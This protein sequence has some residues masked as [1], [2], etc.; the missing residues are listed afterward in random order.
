MGETLVDGF[1]GFIDFLDAI[2]GFLLL[3]VGLGSSYMAIRKVIRRPLDELT[4]KIESLRTETRA[5]NAAQDA[6]LTEIENKIARMENVDIEMWRDRLQEAHN[7]YVNEKKW[8]PP[9]EKQRI[10]RLYTAYIES[11]HNH[12]IQT[13]REDIES[14]TE[15]PPENA[16]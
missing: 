4:A 8:C 12:L 2:K 9:A 15:I 1:K 7:H 14:L 11:H 16:Q 6:K 10:L 13:Y 3:L 5:S